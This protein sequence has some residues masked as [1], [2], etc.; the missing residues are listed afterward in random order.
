MKRLSLSLVVA[1]V[2]C[3]AASGAGAATFRGAVVGTDAARHAIAVA[4]PGGVVR[5]VR[6]QRM[7]RLGAQV[8]VS[9]SRRPDGTFRAARVTASGHARHAR[10][11][12]VVVRRASARTFLSA[13]GTVLAVRSSARPKPG[14]VVT[15]DVSIRKDGLHGTKIIQAGQ[16][17]LIE[18]EGTVATLSPLAITI[19]HGA[20]I[21]LVIPAALALPAGLAVGDEVEAVISFADGV[22]TLVT[23]ETD[24]TAEQGGDHHDHGDEVETKGTVT[25]LSDDHTSLTVQ[26]SEG[27]GTPVT[28]VVP[29]GFDLSG[30]QVGSKVEAKGSMQ[31]GVLTLTK[32]KLEDQ[33]EHKGGE[34]QAEGAVTALADDHTSLTVQPKDEEDGSGAP[35]TFV[36][37]AGFDLSGV[38]VGS[39]VEAKGTMQNEVLTLTELELKDQGDDGENNGD[40]SGGD[41]GGDDG[42]GDGGD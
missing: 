28:F 24:A 23:I 34:V 4:S 18:I 42:G 1:A 22:Y 5:T 29:T 8:S 7:Q 41:N 21:Q 11:H 6:V 14:R 33:G 13:G 12:G 25:A 10:I 15:F 30:V 27:G 3:W 20:T 38:Q 35:V 17:A 32:L 36:V 37:P 31:N 9:G 26:P 40:G 16:T 2:A 39:D 19:E